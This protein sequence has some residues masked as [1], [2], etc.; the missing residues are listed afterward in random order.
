MNKSIRLFLLSVLM[1]AALVLSACS[2]AVPAGAAPRVQQS[3][4]FTGTIEAINGNQWTISGQTITVAPSAL[5]GQFVVGD[6]VQVQGAVATDGTITVTGIEKPSADSATQSPEI[7]TETPDVSST[8]DVSGTPQVGET[9]NPNEVVGLITAMDA[10]TITIDG[11][12]YNLAAFSKIDGSIQVGDTVKLE[13]ITNAD[14]TLTVREVNVASGDSN[15]NGN[16]NGNVNSNENGNGNGNSNDN[17]NGNS[18]D[19]GNGNDNGKDSGNSNDNGSNENG[20]GSVTAGYRI[21]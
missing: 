4:I 10:T 20:H 13:F 16:V 7:G 12:V 21:S 11:V 15:D 1:L 17:G 6:T 3:I 9:P 19:N 8:P 5:K 2:G 14:G 18:N